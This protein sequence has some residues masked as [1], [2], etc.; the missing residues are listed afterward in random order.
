MTK[1][2]LMVKKMT[3]KSRKFHTNTAVF[4]FL[5]LYGCFVCFAI[6]D[7]LFG[8]VIVVLTLWRKL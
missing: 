4:G 2:V 5:S 1:E 8:F 6:V 3:H 7:Y